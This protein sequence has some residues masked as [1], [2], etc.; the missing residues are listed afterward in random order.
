[1]L[2]LTYVILKLVFITHLSLSLH[3]PLRSNCKIRQSHGCELVLLQKR[4]SVERRPLN[5]SKGGP[6]FPLLRNQDDVPMHATWRRR[7]SIRH[8][9][10]PR[11]NFVIVQG[12]LPRQTLAIDVGIEEVQII[13]IARSIQVDHHDGKKRFCRGHKAYGRVEVAKRFV[14]VF[15]HH[16]DGFPKSYT[17]LRRGFERDN[18]QTCKNFA[19]QQCDFFKPFLFLQVAKKYALWERGS[20]H[21]RQTRVGNGFA[22]APNAPLLV[23]ACSHIFIPATLVSPVRRLPFNRPDSHG[24]AQTTYHREGKKPQRRR[25]LSVLK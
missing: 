19:F 8:Q 17:H 3:Y 21:F 24:G 10:F 18:V 9:C 14:V 2:L 15:P 13:P 4:S 7:R 6:R 25:H 22:F 1:M 16:Q 20:M 11:S 5:L 23:P 12:D